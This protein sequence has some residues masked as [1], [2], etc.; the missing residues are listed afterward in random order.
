[1]N[2]PESLFN[3]EIKDAFLE[4]TNI[5]IG[6]AAA[7]LSELS[8]RPVEMTVP[9]M[10]VCRADTLVLPGDL[11]DKISVRVHQD[12]SGGF[13]GKGVLVLNKSGALRLVSLL[14]GEDQYDDAFD[15]NEQSALLELGNMMI[16]GVIGTLS[17]E[18]GT[19]LDFGIPD[20]QLMGTTGGVDLISDVIED[21]HSNVILLRA[22]LKIGVEKISGYLILLF[23][24]ASLDS[25]VKL[26]REQV[27]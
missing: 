8:G 14:L 15:E 25:L 19:Y 4:L 23:A 11:E 12:F 27:S 9:E 18:L 24:P 17:S 26:L 10:D 16:N 22:S 21:K 1:V 13:V 2:V 3:D 20:I 6:R 5:G 7:T